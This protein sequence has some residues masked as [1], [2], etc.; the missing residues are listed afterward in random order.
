M[1]SILEKMLKEFGLNEKEIVVYFACLQCGPS[2]A[3]YVARKAKI[4]RSSCYAILDSLI[5][6]GLVNKSGA[7]KKFQFT[8]EPPERL[9]L[10]IQEKQKKIT[11]LERKYVKLLPELKSLYDTTEELP[12]IRFL[13]GVK[14]I[15]S[16]Y[17]DTLKT[18]PKGGEY[19]HL[20]PDIKALM[21]LIGEEWI[22]GNIR[23]RVSQGIKSK[24]IIEKT[25][26]VEKEIKKNKQAYRESVLL[27]KEI[28]MPARLHIYAN[29]VAI[30]SLKKEPT[31]VLIED[32]NVADLIKM[33]YQALW[34]KYKK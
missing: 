20:N 22:E 31:G 17:E 27:P 2:Y 7:E 8:A 29:K 28:K 18:L 32:K 4:N 13:E 9:M 5:K 26:W 15:K 10:L 11:D 19:W 1:S 34:D 3:T 6:H 25:P 24:A 21:D 12:K 16:I 23:K 30:F 14:G 33:L